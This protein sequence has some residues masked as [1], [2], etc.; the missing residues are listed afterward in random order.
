MEND[1][2]RDG[3]EERNKPEKDLKQRM[4]NDLSRGFEGMNFEQQ[5]SNYNNSDARDNSS[6]DRTSRDTEETR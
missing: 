1:W 6:D 5:R 4:R 2:G 3:N